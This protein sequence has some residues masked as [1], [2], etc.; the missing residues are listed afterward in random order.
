MTSAHSVH[1]ASNS[2][3]SAVDLQAWMLFLELGRAGERAKFHMGHAVYPYVLLC[4]FVLSAAVSIALTALI[5][6]HA[7]LIWQGQVHK[8]AVLLSI[9]LMH[10][11]TPAYMHISTAACCMPAHQCFLICVLCDV[12]EHPRMKYPVAAR[13]SARNVHV[14]HSVPH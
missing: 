3:S 4:P 2:V 8:P 9:K 5:G 11:C 10:S 14:S 1:T 7:F 13:L 6:W 12:G